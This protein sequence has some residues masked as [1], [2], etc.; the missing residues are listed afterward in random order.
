[1]KPDLD[2]LDRLEKEATPLPLV[3][4]RYEHGGGRLFRDPPPGGQ[5]PFR[6]VADFY[7]E[8]PDREFFAS[9]RNAAPY[10]LAAAR[11]AEDVMR[12]GEWANLS[13][14]GACLTC[15]EAIADDRGHLTLPHRE[16]CAFEAF[17][18]LCLGS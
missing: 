12:G 11:L 14:E 16:G 6:L 15:G 9:L 7:G 10:L 5:D 13:E 8:G 3:L 2:A 18:V 1:M 4:T 17:R